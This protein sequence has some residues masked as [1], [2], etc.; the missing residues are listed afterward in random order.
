[1][2]HNLEWRDVRALFE[3]F[4]NVEVEHNGNLRV[5]VGANSVVFHSPQDTDIATSDQVSQIRKLIQG[6][7][8]GPADG[9]GPHLLVVMD[10]K[11]A[12]VFRTE[13]KDSVPERVVPFDPEGHRGHVHSPHE[14]PG[15]S[16]HPNDD[17][18]YESINGTLGDAEQILF[19]GSGAGSSNAMESFLTWLRANHPR[20]AERV[21]GVMTVDESHLTEGQ[22][23]AKAREV[24]A[25]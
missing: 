10:H 23:L 21:T 16:E 19:F 15:S 25:R 5:T 18:Y 22:L 20:I 6:S 24:Y 14:Y 4:G 8:V 7:G 12:R 1:M 2:T 9:M 11:E 13:M 3:D 17:A